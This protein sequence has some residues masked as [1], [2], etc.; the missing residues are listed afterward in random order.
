MSAAARV[1]LLEEPRV[2]EL[3]SDGLTLHGYEIATVLTRL[4]LPQVL[5]AEHTVLAPDSEEAQPLYARYWLHN[6]GPAALGGLPAIAYLHPHHIAAEPNSPVRLRL[7][8]ASDCSDAVLHG[9]VR[10]RCPDG[11]AADPARLSFVLPP[12]E[13]LETD[14]LLTAPAE[15]VPGLYPV[16]AELVLT[17][18]HSSIP[19]AW[20]QVVEDVCVVSVGDPPDDGLLRLVSGPEPVD[21]SAGETARLA[22]TVGT[23]AHADLAVEAHLISPWGTWEWMGPPASGLELAAR[24]TAELS[25]EVAPP[26]W[27]EPGEWWALIRVAAAGQLLYSPAVKVTVR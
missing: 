18:N 20:R 16:R 3:P 12:G 10:L 13:H 27:V 6:R 22:V 25:F 11:W 26:E 1:D 17:G 19:P 5:D 9:R 4:N 8:A 21:V 24:S 23:D 7:T 15:A 2:Q 14:V